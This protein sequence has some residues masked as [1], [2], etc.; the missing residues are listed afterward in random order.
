MFT[1]HPKRFLQEEL[2]KDTSSGKEETDVDGKTGSTA[3]LVVG[4]LVRAAAALGTLTRAGLA[5]SILVGLL[6]VGLAVEGTLD[7]T[8]ASLLAGS[9][10]LE[11]LA[12]FGDIVGGSEIES[13]TD[14]LELGELDPAVKISSQ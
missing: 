10:L 2:G 6:V 7:L 12:G 14:A 1:S 9:Q 8:V 3:V 5:G 13:A 11:G 4:V